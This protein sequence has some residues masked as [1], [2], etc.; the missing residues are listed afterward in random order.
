MHFLHG[1]RIIHMDLKSP[2]ILLGSNGEAK[3]A[4]VGLA[5]VMGSESIANQVVCPRS[6]HSI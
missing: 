1:R 3:I 6:C 5:R 2:N 4:D